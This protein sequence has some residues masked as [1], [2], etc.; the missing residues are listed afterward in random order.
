MKQ[1]SAQNDTRVSYV[2]NVYEFG[3]YW[4]KKKQCFHER[5]PDRFSILKQNRILIFSLNGLEIGDSYVSLYS[6][7]T[8]EITRVI[9]MF[10][11]HRYPIHTRV[12]CVRTMRSN[13]FT[14]VIRMFRLHRYPI[15]TSDLCET[16]LRKE[17]TR[18]CRMFRMYLRYSMDPMNTRELCE[19]MLRKEMTRENR[20]FRMYRLDTNQY[21]CSV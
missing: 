19:T 8:C 1:C 15:H 21:E 9:R 7:S 5:D 16:M 3:M 11:L 14:R 18:E 10:R 13:D 20:M 6:M 17:M 12:I 2:F 4:K